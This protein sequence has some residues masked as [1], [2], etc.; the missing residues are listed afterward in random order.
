MEW[1]DMADQKKVVDIEAV[2]RILAEADQ[3]VDGALTEEERKAVAVLRRRAVEKDTAEGFYAAGEDA[4]AA[5]DFDLLA[6]ADA[7]E[8]LAAKVRAVVEIKEA[9]L[10]QKA[11]DVYY[12][13]E[14]LAR[15]PANAHLKEQVE[16]MRDAHERQYGKPIPPKKGQ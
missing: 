11:L 7:L 1:T 3:M 15:D 14:E 2:M 5:E 4:Q 8:S 9:A 6:T 12:A 10:Y 16:K 13:T